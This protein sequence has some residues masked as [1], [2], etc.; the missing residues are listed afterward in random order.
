M[1]KKPLVGQRVYVFTKSRE[2]RGS[3]TIMEVTETQEGE[4]IIRVDEPPQGIQPGDMIAYNLPTD[5]QQKEGQF[6]NLA[7][8]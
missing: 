7:R 8:H 6:L 1:K 2:V 4:C 3:C 5:T